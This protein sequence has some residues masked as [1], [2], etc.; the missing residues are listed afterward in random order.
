M[1]QDSRF[2]W[3]DAKAALNFAKHRVR[4]EDASLV[5]NDPMAIDE[6]DQSSSFAEDRWINIGMSCGRIFF[7]SYTMNGDR[8]RIISARGAEPYEKRRYFQEPR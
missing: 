7:V 5:F 6:E 4:F 3:D 1:V 2:E 8:I